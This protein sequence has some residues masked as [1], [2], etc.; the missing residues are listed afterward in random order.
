MDPSEGD[1][2]ESGKQNK[3]S[4]DTY[5]NAQRTVW[6]TWR[7]YFLTTLSLSL[8]LSLRHRMK[9]S[10]QF[11]D[12]NSI[13]VIR[14]NLISF[15]FSSQLGSA[16]FF[17]LNFL[18]GG[19]GKKDGADFLTCSSTYLIWAHFPLPLNCVGSR[20]REPRQDNGATIESIYGP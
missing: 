16:C 3:T 5:R 2:S 11:L 13:S 14:Q 8:S 9:S 17:A 4:F 6:I 20:E 1:Q 7:C 12:I 19:G 15:S 10:R 18:V